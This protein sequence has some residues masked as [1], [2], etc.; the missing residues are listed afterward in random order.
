MHRTVNGRGK[1]SI[2]LLVAVFAT[3][4]LPQKVKVGYDKGVDF[5]K[6]KTYTLA[7]P[8]MPP[9]RPVLYGT[10]IRSIDAE[11][12]SKRFQRVDKNGDLTLQVAGV[13]DFGIAVSGGPPLSSSYGGPPPAINATMWTGAGGQGALMPPVGDAS[14][15]LEFIDQKANQIVWSGTVTQALDIE[16]KEEALEL[17]RKAVT[18]LL[19]RFPANSSR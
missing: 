9:T 3:S 18:K 15:Q 8:A 19:K 10:V 4:A 1:L 13:V 17:A 16:R 6:Y 7:E 14:L 5:S 12:S 11:L 2:G